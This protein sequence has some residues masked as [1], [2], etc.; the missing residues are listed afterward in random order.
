MIQPRYEPPSEKG[1]WLFWP[2]GGDELPSIIKVHTVARRSPQSGEV[3]VSPGEFIA[4]E[5]PVGYLRGMWAGPIVYS[6]IPVDRLGWGHHSF[7]CRHVDGKFECVEDCPTGLGKIDPR[8][9]VKPMR[10][11]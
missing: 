5:T 3:E 7:D 9:E 11:D 10:I 1:L 6:R 4:L 2:E 8:V